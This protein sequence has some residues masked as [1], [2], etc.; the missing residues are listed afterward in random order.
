[1]RERASG[2]NLAL[3]SLGA[4]LAIQIY[5]SFAG[6]ATAVL[7][8][9]IARDLDVDA[10]WIGV[11]IGLVYVGGMFASL[12][13]GTFIRR[14][15]AIRVSQACVLICAAGIGA[16]AALPAHAIGVAA[17]SAV[18]IGIGY[19]A[20]TPASSHVLARTTP[21]HRMSLVFSIKQT[22]V[23]AGVALGGMLLPGLA[24]AFGWRAAFAGAAF[25]GLG[26]MLVAQPIRD[27]L[28]ADRQPALPFTFATIS[29]PLGIVLRTPALLRL[30]SASFAYSAV[31]VSLTSFMVVFLTA[32]LHWSLVAAGLV[33][34]LTTLGGVVG[35]IGWG[36]IA[37]RYNAPRKVLALI[38]ALAA[39]CALVL[40]FAVPDWPLMLVAIAAA[41]F[42]ATAIGWNGVQ[43]AEVARLAPRGKAGAVTGASGFI[44]FFGVVVGPPAFA[45]IAGTAA[46]YPGAFVMLAV[47]A[48]TGAALSLAS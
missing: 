15:G 46:G 6:T 35:R 45:A 2:A 42:G 30:A 44:T 39:I 17:A 7:A 40:A 18:V 27:A 28:D 1:M 33:L 8:P 9:E 34:T 48:I 43:L 25:A 19:G 37:D 10:K 26:V 4:T 3:A 20:I 24:V 21:A 13:S 36:A 22:G 14:H 41:I 12:V 29:E 47:L 31:Q 11:F 16:M 38:G 5:T 23:P 32:M